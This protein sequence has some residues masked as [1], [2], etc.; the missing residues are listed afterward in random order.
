MK[1]GAK[2]HFLNLDYLEERKTN[3]KQERGFLFVC[4]LFSLLNGG[5][6]DNSRKIS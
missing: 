6:I 5:Q 2:R 1:K 4:F 3:L